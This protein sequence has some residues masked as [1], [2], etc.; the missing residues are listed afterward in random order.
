MGLL[1]Q[2]KTK[3]KTASSVNQQLNNSRDISSIP[4]PPV[5]AKEGPWA[6]PLPSLYPAYYSQQHLGKIWP[7]SFWWVLSRRGS[8]TGSAQSIAFDRSVVVFIWRKR[9]SRPN[10][11]TFHSPSVKPG[12][13][14][15]TLCQQDCWVCLFWF[16]L[17]KACRIPSSN[18]SAITFGSRISLYLTGSSFFWDKFCGKKGQCCTKRASVFALCTSAAYRTSW[19]QSLGP[20]FLLAF[21]SVVPLK[22]LLPDKLQSIAQPYVDTWTE[23]LIFSSKLYLKACLF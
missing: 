18:S 8:Q 20:N 11:F 1:N 16:V 2:H 4:F 22:S 15:S 14:K 17:N 12:R 6:V 21:F 7:I 3:W 19:D 10:N 5:G 23:W 13:Q 9:E